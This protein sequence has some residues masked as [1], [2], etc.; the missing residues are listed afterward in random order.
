M[1]DL[2]PYINSPYNIVTFK[3]NRMIKKIFCEESPDNSNDH[4]EVDFDILLFCILKG[5]DK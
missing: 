3:H 5:I 1:N 4:K 2:H